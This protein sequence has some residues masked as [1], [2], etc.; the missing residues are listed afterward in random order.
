MTASMASFQFSTPASEAP[1]LLAQLVT[2]VPLNNR[3]RRS[4]AKNMKK[5]M[6][7]SS[8]GLIY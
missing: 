1:R 8:R 4:I 5:P 6:R 7:M 2:T 3:T